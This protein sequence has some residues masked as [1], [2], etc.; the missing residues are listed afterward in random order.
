MANIIQVVF[1]YRVNRG[2][3]TVVLGVV[4]ILFSVLG[5][6]D[7]IL[8]LLLI[9]GVTVPPIGGI[10]IAD[11]F[12]LKRDREALASTRASLKLPA[13]CEAVNPAGLL[14]WLAGFLAG[15]FVNWGIAAL[16]SIVVAGVLYFV[17][18]RILA[19][20]AKQPVKYFSTA[21]TVTSQL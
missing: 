3:L 7:H 11:Y 12:L 2:I 13:F 1:G 21:P 16:N 14:A 15:Y 10:F 18:M 6:L 20:L 9:L 5:I 4:G 17:L 8:G 19:V